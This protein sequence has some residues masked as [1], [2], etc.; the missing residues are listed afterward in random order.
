MGHKNGFPLVQFDTQTGR[1]KV[2]AFS[3]DYFFER[4]G[5]G[6]LCS[7]GIEPSRDG[8]SIFAYINGTFV[9]EREMTSYGRPSII[10]IPASERA[11]DKFKP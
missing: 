10:H 4:Y 1:K 3:F 6:M 9:P 5:Y 7:Y 2:L 8:S 11:G